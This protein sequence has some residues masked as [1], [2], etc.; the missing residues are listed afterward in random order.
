MKDCLY[1]KTYATIV[2]M[3]PQP[4]PGYAPPWPEWLVIRRDGAPEG[5]REA[6]PMRWKNGGRSSTL[7]CTGKRIKLY[8]RPQCPHPSF[9]L[10]G[11]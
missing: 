8:Q 11:D 5:T 1:P 10:V 2:G 3:F 9:R 4:G 7:V 6:I